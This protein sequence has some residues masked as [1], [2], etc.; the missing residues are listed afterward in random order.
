MVMKKILIAVALLAVLLSCS[1]ERKQETDPPTAAQDERM[2]WWRDARFGMFVHWGLYA[3]PAGEWKGEKI[4]GISEWIM[5]RAK[6]PVKEYE[7]LVKFL[8]LQQQQH[9]LYS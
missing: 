8:Q 3:E 5:L 2:E 7:K 9:L 1:T 4:P 6:I